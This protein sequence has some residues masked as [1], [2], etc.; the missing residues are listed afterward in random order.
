MHVKHYIQKIQGNLTEH[1]IER[2]H[3]TSQM[4]CLFETDAMFF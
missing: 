1:I 3:V 4:W 2:I